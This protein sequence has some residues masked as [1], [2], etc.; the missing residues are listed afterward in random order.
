MAGN[1]IREKD[2]SGLGVIKFFNPARAGVEVTAD[3]EGLNVKKADQGKPFGAVLREGDVVTTIGTAK[4]GSVEAFRKVLRA[5]GRR[6]ITLTVRRDGKAFG[7][8]V[9]DG[10]LP[11]S[12]GKRVSR[13]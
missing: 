3:D 1:I 9:P 13:Q 2:T 5:A 8:H 11:R 6:F 10:D 7:V 4:V 12:P